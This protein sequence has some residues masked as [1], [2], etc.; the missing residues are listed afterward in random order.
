MLA[1]GLDSPDAGIT[2]W[3]AFLIFALIAGLVLAY[4][5]FTNGDDRS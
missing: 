4:A 5:Y 1:T 3:D 2:G